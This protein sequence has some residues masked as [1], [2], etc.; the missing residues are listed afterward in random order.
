MA[1]RVYN[2]FCSLALSL[3]IVGERWTLLLVRELMA[4]PKR[5]TDLAGA[6]DG[7]GS[8]LLAARLRQLEDDGII[9]QRQLPPPTAATVYEL[10][11][12]GTELA[13]A[14]LPLVLWGARHRARAPRPDEAYRAEWALVFIAQMIDRDALT[15]LEYTYRFQLGESEAYLR[16]SHND[17]TVTPGPL[18]RFDATAGT[19][20][21]TVLEISAGRLALSEALT[22]GRVTLDG[23]PDALLTLTRVLPD[24]IPEHPRIALDNVPG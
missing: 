9:R 20:P 17:V 8:S 15:G 16:I 11:T 13:E 21:V 22:T 3:D 5:Y 14:M 1:R 4:G 18:D 6:L 12:A 10:T 2:Q 24:R 7:I 19:D 23:D